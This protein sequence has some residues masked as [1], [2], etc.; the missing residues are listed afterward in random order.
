MNPEYQI[1]LRYPKLPLVDVGGQ[2]QNLLP[3]E[4]CEILPNQ[5]FRGKLLDDQ[6]AKMIT[7]AAKPPNVNGAAIIGPGLNHLGYRGTDLMKQFGVSIGQEM[8]V[9]PGRILRTSCGVVAESGLC[10]K[11]QLATRDVYIVVLVASANA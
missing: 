8:A 2:K 6:T 7:V 5:P 4:V 9:V 3:P 11:E 10:G 1:T